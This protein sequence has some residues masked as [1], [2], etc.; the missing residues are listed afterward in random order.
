MRE[1]VEDFLA[2]HGIDLDGGRVLLAAHPRV[3]GFC[4][5]PLSVFW[6]LA[7]AATRPCVIVEVHNTYGERHCYLLRPDGA[8]ARVPPR[9]STSRRST[10]S[11]V[12]TG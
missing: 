9:P 5:N 7:R 11:T 6:C 2:A 1:N 12:S 8:G 4:F 10:T 3:F